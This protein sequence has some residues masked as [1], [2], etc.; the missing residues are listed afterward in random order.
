MSFALR[1]FQRLSHPNVATLRCSWRHNRYTRGMSDHGPL[2]LESG[3]LKFPT[4]TTDRDRTV[5]RRSEPSS[6]ATLIGE[7]PN[8]WDLLQPQDV[9]S[10]HRGAKPPVD[11]SSWERS[12]CY[13]RSTFYPLSDGPSIR[14]HRITLPYFRTC[15]TCQSHSQAPL[16]QYTLR[17]VTNRAEGTFESLRYSFG[18]DH[19]S[20]TTHH[21][22]SPAYAG[23]DSK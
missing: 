1:C 11:M 14:N 8:P 16:C 5:S 9:T 12:A 7:Q 13:P 17:T 23:L 6:R 18:G 15:S 10:R 20:Q 19:P 2:V 21:A 4:P 22:L 3:P